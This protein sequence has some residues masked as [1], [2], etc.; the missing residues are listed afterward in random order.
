MITYKN[1][2]KQF[3]PFLLLA[4]FLSSCAS[5]QKF[6]ERGDYERAI[7]TAVKKLSGKKI[8]K[9]KYVASLEEAFEKANARDLN[10]ATRL[11]KEGRGENWEQINTIYKRIRKRQEMVEP[12]LPLIDKHGVKANFKF[13]RIE[14][15][16]LESKEKAAEYLYVHAKQLLNQAKNGDKRAARDAYDEFGKIKKYYRDYLDVRQLKE[17]A[18]YLGTSHIVFEMKNKAPV[19]LPTGFDRELKRITLRDLNQGWKVFHPSMESNFQYDYKVVMNITNIDVSPERIKEREYEESKDI[20]DGFDYVL[21]E[22][23][24]VMKDSL[25][26][27]IKVKK[28]VMVRARIFESYQSKAARVGGRLEFFDLYNNELIESR[29]INVEALFENYASTFDG[30]KRALTK[31]T[32]RHIGNRP[33]PFPS[34]ESLLLQ[35]ADEMKPVIKQMI[36][37]SRKLF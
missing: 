13:V 7:R 29:P 19:I 33:V 24:N 12:L 8:K 22:N 9:A 34:D 5:P 27:D 17:E 36:S 20:Q 16:E 23:G 1:L 21:D 15:L 11:K 4:F 30:D 28:M 14:D 26:N 32:K 37:D 10:M 2:S 3:I 31:E 6:V 35:A 18:R 25:G